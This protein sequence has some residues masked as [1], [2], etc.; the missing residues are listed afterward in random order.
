[1]PKHTSSKTNQVYLNRDDRD[2]LARGLEQLCSYCRRCRKCSSD[3]D[4]RE[5][6]E[7]ELAEIA[8][9]ANR[10]GLESSDNSWEMQSN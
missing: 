2:R 4:D 9:L 8:A 3:D 6:Y 10:L 7:I 5:Y 1:M